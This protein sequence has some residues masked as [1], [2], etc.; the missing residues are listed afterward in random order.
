MRTLVNTTTTCK[1]GPPQ[2][3][4]PAHARIPIPEEAGRVW[5]GAPLHRPATDRESA[6]SL[7]GH[8]WVYR[9]QNPGRLRRIAQDYGIEPAGR[10]DDG[11]GERTLEARA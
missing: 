11:Y 9:I 4:R 6:I 2:G 5:T 8:R 7:P 1:T 3:Q 10:D